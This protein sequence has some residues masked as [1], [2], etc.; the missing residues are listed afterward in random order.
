[1]R[2]SDHSRH[3]S[4][5]TMKPTFREFARESKWRWGC[6]KIPPV[7][8]ATIHGLSGRVKAGEAL[9]AYK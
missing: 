9:S 7:F 3:L 5:R 1:M 2:R 6:H 8:G 4:L